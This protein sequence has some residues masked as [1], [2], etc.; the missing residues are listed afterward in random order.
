MLEEVFG[1]QPEL[2]QLKDVKKRNP[3]HLAAYLGYLDG[4]EFLLSKSG[5]I[6]FAFEHDED[7]QLPIHIPCKVRHLSVVIAIKAVKELLG[8]WPNPSE[9]L[10]KQERNILHIAA[11]SGRAGIVRRMLKM[12]EL[13]LLI[14]QRDKDGNTPIHLATFNW[15]PLVL[16][17]LA[18][19]KRANVNLVN[20]QCST[21]FDFAKNQSFG[22]H[23]PL[24]KVLNTTHS[25]CLFIFNIILWFQ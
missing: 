15:Y 23:Q 21:A 18:L 4:I 13:R 22:F 2:F 9:L 25:F 1:R 5:T 3:L 20:E 8:Q 7:G 14:N 12:S 16:Y 19:D 10:D 24:R 6:S 17:Y 11:M